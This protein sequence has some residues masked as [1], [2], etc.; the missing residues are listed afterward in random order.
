[1]RTE[2]IRQNAFYFLVSLM[3]VGG[4]YH[5]R[6][7]IH[8]PCEDDFDLRLWSCDHH[9]RFSARQNVRR[10]EREVCETFLVEFLIQETSVT[11]APNLFSQVTKVPN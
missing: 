6:S 4:W 1:M 3:R 10:S 9:E 11:V 5:D 7:R 2:N 8:M